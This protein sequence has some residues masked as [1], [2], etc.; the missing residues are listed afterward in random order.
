MVG[1]YLSVIESIS[2]KKDALRLIAQDFASGKIDEKTY[3][4]KTSSLF[5]EIAGLKSLAEQEENQKK[6]YEAT[7]ADIVGFPVFVEDKVMGRI[8][9]IT[10]FEGKPA[11]ILTGMTCPQCKALIEEHAKF[12]VE[13]GASL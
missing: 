2:K 8:S 11:L 13:C 7:Y 10:V 3:E 6:Q 12:C 5:T 4:E 1:G 9:G